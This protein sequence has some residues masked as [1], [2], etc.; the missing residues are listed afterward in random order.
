[1]RSTV[2]RMT[3][4]SGTAPTRLERRKERTRQAMIDAAKRIVAERGTVSVTITEITDEADVGFGSFYNHFESKHEL[5]EIALTEVLEDYGQALDRACEELVDPA[6][7]YAVG[8]RMS[9]RLPFERPAVAQV[10]VQANAE[11]L[12]AEQGL[13]MRALRDIGQG[14]DAGRFTLGDAQLGLMLTVGGC[15]EFIRAAMA[16]PEEFTTEDA[17]SLAAMLLRAL[18][19]SGPDADEIAHRAL[20]V[21]G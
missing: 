15:L 20:P 17:D 2:D 9:A 1:M 7:R 8:V 5:F 13:P 6:E 10:L 16:Q 19:M 11:H 4:D 3:V 14:L 21:V 12:T 18:G